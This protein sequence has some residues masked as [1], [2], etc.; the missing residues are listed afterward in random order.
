MRRPQ[1]RRRTGV[2]SWPE[3]TCH[4]HILVASAPVRNVHMQARC[5]AAPRSTWFLPGD[6]AAD[7]VV[8]G[9]GGQA[10]LDEQRAGVLAER[11]DVTHR[12]L[13]V[14][15]GRRGEEGWGGAGWLRGVRARSG[16]PAT[17]RGRAAAG[18]R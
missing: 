6:A 15:E 9:V 16:S 17:G 4:I 11:W 8:G 5:W 3:L 7:E 12:R 10:G 14:G 2:R 13:L 1:L 18:A